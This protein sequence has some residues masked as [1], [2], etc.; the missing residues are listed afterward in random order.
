M[1]LC[2][3]V[4]IVTGAAS[5]IGEACAKKV[6]QEGA[7]VVVADRDEAN[8]RRVAGEIRAGGGESSFFLVDVCSAS[9]V[10]RAVAHTVATHGALHLAVNNVGM[11]HAPAP[12]HQIPIATID[13]IFSVNLRA[14]MLCMREELAHFVAHGGGAIVNISSVAGLKASEGFAAY[15]AAK[16]GVVGLTRNGALEY[17][18][19]NIRINAIAPGSIRTPPMRSQPQELQDKHNGMS[20]MARMGTPEEIANAV[21]FLLSDQASYI[22]GTVVEVDGGFMQAS[23]S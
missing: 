11:A 12:L 4:A 16:H 7:A 20:P 18:T 2:G 3:N 1:T 23:R 15:A 6:A 9:E 14:V 21:A 10:E 17:A 8:G 19:Q 5:G 22:T 13:R